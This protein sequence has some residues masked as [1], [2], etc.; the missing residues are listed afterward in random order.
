MIVYHDYI[1]VKS[2]NLILN[3]PY[4]NFDFELAPALFKN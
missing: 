2:I 3:T 1:S 4:L